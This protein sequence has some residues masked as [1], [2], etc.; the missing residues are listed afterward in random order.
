MLLSLLKMFAI[1]KMRL[2]YDKENLEKNVVEN[3]SIMCR[4][5]GKKTGLYLRNTNTNYKDMIT[6]FVLNTVLHHVGM[7][8]IIETIQQLEYDIYK[9]NP[10]WI[11]Y[12][13]WYNTSIFTKLHGRVFKKYI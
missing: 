6:K 2:W 4:N 3:V 7:S 5:C 1:F 13:T 12:G 8:W 10:D 11:T 9:D